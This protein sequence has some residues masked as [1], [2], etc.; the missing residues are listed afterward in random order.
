MLSNSVLFFARGIASE[1]LDRPNAWRHHES[2]TNVQT[3]EVLQATYWMHSK[4][5][6]AQGIALP[7]LQANALKFRHVDIEAL[8]VRFP[9]ES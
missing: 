3:A 4:A 2:E 5:A 6:R 8:N 9:C 7:F 1:D